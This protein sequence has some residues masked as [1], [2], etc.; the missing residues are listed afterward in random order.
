MVPVS[1]THLNHFEGNFTAAPEVLRALEDEGRV[2]LRYLDNPNGS[3]DGIAGISNAEGNVAVSYTHLDVYKRQAL[4]EEGPPI[5][6][7]GGRGVNVPA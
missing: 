6:R 2:V 5:E 4:C 3:V 7:S 1:Y